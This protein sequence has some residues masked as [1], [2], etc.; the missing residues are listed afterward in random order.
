MATINMYLIST[1]NIIIPNLIKL[2]Y[3]FSKYQKTKYIYGFF[4]DKLSLKTSKDERVFKSNIDLLQYLEKLGSKYN[5]RSKLTK[6]RNTKRIN[7]R[8]WFNRKQ[9]RKSCDIIGKSE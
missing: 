6:N 8:V 9:T 5:D 7:D 4:G 3:I 2:G 1:R